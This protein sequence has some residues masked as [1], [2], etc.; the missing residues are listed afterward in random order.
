MELYDA[1]TMP[2]SSIPDLRMAQKRYARGERFLSIYGRDQRKIIKTI[3][4]YE[5]KPTCCYR[6]IS[7]ETFDI[8]KNLGFICDYRPNSTEYS[9]FVDDNGIV[10]CNNAGIDWYLGGAAPG[11]YGMIVIECPADMN[12]FQ[13]TLDY[14]CDMTLDPM[15]RHMKSSPK[16]NPIPFSMITNVFDCRN[17]LAQ[18][19]VKTEGLEAEKNPNVPQFK[20]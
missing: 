8:Y 1:T 13:P 6:A 3:G 10:Y 4:E 2:L 16:A 5:C 19:P 18:Q 20:R 7:Q 15:V 12:Y 17:I 9:E 14:G 11:K